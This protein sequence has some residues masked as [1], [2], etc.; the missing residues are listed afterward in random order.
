[1]VC[2]HC[3]VLSSSLSGESHSLAASSISEAIS[4]NVTAVGFCRWSPA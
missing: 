2:L 1:M 3:P 4:I